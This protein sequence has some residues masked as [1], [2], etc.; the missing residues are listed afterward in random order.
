MGAYQSTDSSSLSFWESFSSVFERL[1]LVATEEFRIL[2][3]G[4]DA[5]GKGTILYKLKSGEV[6]SRCIL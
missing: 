2:M 1:G 3:I 4:L 6:G 5:A